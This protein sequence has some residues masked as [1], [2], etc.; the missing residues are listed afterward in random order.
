MNLVL[1]QV[2]H[3]GKVSVSSSSVNVWPFSHTY[4]PFPGFSPVVHIIVLSLILIIKGA[5]MLKLIKKLFK[6][7]KTELFILIDNKKIIKVR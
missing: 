3:G 6:K 5:K 7:Q 4:L 2:G 1:L